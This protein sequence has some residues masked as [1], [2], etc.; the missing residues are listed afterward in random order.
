M[1]YAIYLILDFQFGR[2]VCM[3]AGAVGS[4]LAA[5]L[6]TDLGTGLWFVLPYGFGVRLT[7][8]ALQFIS[9][10]LPI[11]SAEVK[12]GIGMCAIMSVLF[13]T[14]LLLWFLRYS[15]QYANK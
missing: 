7:E 3:S 1:L 12:L 14:I 4:L 9:C 8:Y 15:G 13:I 10:A 5:L 6:Q 11:A 2:T